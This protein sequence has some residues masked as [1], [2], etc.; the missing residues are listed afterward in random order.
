MIAMS[1]NDDMLEIHKNIENIISKSEKN[2]IINYAKT[3]ESLRTSIRKLYDKYA[4]KQ[5]KLSFVQ[6]NVKKSNIFDTKP[7]I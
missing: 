1:L 3:L 7:I 5:S 4:D 6:M 2:I